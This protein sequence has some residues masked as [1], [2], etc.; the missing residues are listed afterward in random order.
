MERSAG[1]LWRRTMNLGGLVLACFGHQTSICETTNPS[2]T[3]ANVTTKITTRPVLDP[4]VAPLSPSDP[5]AWLRQDPLADGARFVRQ[6]RGGPRRCGQRR[7]RRRT[8]GAS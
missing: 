3:T 5:Q 6:S 8:E 1:R 4:I 7:E 2:H